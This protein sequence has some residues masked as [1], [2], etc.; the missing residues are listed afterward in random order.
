VRR[1]LA[2]AGL[3]LL[4]LAIGCAGEQRPPEPADEVRAAA[5]AYVDSLRAGHWADACDRMTAAA[6]AA[7]ADGR[8]S[9]PRQLRG[10]GALPRDVL[11]TVAR[12]LAGA[13]VRISHETA[14]LGPVADLPEPLRFK[15]VAGR[16]LVAP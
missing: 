13:P 1:R 4:I 6:R 10:G 15:R 16:W 9:C 5:T 12:Q 2:V 8:R 7:V 14:V 11:D 3:G